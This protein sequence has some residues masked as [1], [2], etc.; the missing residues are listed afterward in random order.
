MRDGTRG[1]PFR[2]CR[3]QNG[4]NEK[5]RKYQIMVTVWSKTAISCTARGRLNVASHLENP[6]EVS[7]LPEHARNL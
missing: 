4:Y 5:D 3:D 7:T 2:S 1:A 6:L